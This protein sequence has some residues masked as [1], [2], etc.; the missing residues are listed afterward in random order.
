M[1]PQRDAVIRKR[2][3]VA[4]D[5]ADAELKRT[6]CPE[7]VNYMTWVKSPEHA[8]VQEYRS[9][10]Y[11]VRS[12]ASYRRL[13]PIVRLLH[14]SRHM[15]RRDNPGR[16]PSYALRWWWTDDT[17]DSLKR[18]TRARALT[19][20][21]T[22][23][24]G[25]PN[26]H[27]SGRA[28]FYA[29]HDRLKWSVEWGIGPHT[30]FSRAF[31]FGISIDGEDRDLGFRLKI[32]LVGYVY[33]TFEHV[34]PQWL[35]F[36]KERRYTTYEP[37]VFPPGYEVKPGDRKPVEHRYMMGQDVAVLELDISPDH[38]SGAFW[39][40]GEHMQSEGKRRFYTFWP[41]RIFGRPEHHCEKVGEPVQA[42]ACFPEGQYTL[43][44]QREIRTWT[45]KRWPWPYWRKSV[46]I[47]LERPP[48]FQGKGE[49][50]YDQGP[51]A[52]YG[53][54]SEGH[55]YEDA[56]AAYVKAVLRERA[57]RGHL[58]P[59]HRTVLIEATP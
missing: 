34:V 44:L 12:F 24:V 38:A 28:F 53:M 42:I 8:Q 43:T 55:S 15:G 21:D 5:F 39:S 26:V 52:I 16:E 33:L 30:P 36:P 31:G 45:R 17:D 48:E 3:Q 9:W 7:G 10:L 58:E 1:T 49:S 25:L 13:H 14:R 29:N 35:T 59:Q 32:P 54:S 50:D 18:R 23:A 19:W 41:D 56:V 4:Y 20:G 51:D 11:D 6:D 27:H 46:D 57:K 47:T 2:A 37:T 22:F 40:I